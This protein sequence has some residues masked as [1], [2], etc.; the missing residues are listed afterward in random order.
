[1]LLHHSL[2]LPG[3]LNAL[4]AWVNFWIP[5]GFNIVGEPQNFYTLHI[6][7][8]VRVGWRLIYVPNMKPSTASV[9]QHCTLKVG[10]GERGGGWRE[11]WQSRCALRCD[12]GG[13][14]LVSLSP[15]KNSLRRWQLKVKGETVIPV[16]CGGSFL[17]DICSEEKVV[18]SHVLTQWEF[19]LSDPTCGPRA[20]DPW[21]LPCQR[22]TCCQPGCLTKGLLHCQQQQQQQHTA[23][24]SFNINKCH[25]HMLD[26]LPAMIMMDVQAVRS[27]RSVQLFVIRWFFRELFVFVLLQP[28]GISNQIAGGC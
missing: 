6:L 16:S 7:V 4:L 23:E 9:L 14:L 22:W 11:A 8:V 21:R 17:T 13:E 24:K 18:M 1:M 25:I 5:L 15:P 20:A 28:R 26:T 10:W 3:S 27:Q 19:R 2:T 12:V